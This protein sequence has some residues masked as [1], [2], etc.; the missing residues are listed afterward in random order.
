MPSAAVACVRCGEDLVDSTRPCIFCREERKREAV[1]TLVAAAKSTSN[2]S[3]AARAL[4][5]DTLRNLGYSKDQV[6][7]ARAGAVDGFSVDRILEGLDE[8]RAAVAA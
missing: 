3:L 2:P 4:A 5:I 8:D 1:V 7:M 6:L